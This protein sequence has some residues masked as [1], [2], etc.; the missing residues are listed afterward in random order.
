MSG[1]VNTTTPPAQESH[2]PASSGDR[3]MPGIQQRY[4]S[5]SA[6]SRRSYDGL[7]KRLLKGAFVN[8]GLHA[9]TRPIFR[10]AITRIMQRLALRH[11]SA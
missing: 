6:I 7:C 4:Q 11:V 2:S 10:A 9:I 3:R 5:T 8:P 1:I